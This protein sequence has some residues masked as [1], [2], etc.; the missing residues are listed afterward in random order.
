MY[1]VSQFRSF[2]N[3]L[4]ELTYNMACLS[5]AVR[6]DDVSFRAE[7]NHEFGDHLILVVDLKISAYTKSSLTFLP[8]A[9]TLE[10]STRSRVIRF[11]SYILTIHNLSR[12]VQ[13]RHL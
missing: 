9:Y 7:H 13:G 5:S 8:L 11:S 4:T 2:L 1:A 12:H 3:H 10:L 6:C